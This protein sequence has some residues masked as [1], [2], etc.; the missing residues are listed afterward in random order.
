MP[1]DIEGF[2]RNN[3]DGVS[4]IRGSC[5]LSYSSISTISV[6]NGEDVLSPAS[7]GDSG[8]AG[9]LSETYREW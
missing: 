1:N 8:S 7:A 6:R 9:Q 3:Q 2:F 5:S 4:E